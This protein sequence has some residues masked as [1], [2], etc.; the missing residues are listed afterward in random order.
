MGQHW[1]ATEDGDVYRFDKR[2]MQVVK[3]STYVNKKGY[4]VT[5][6]QG[7]QYYVHRLVAEMYLDTWNP[8]LQVNHKDGNKLNNRADNLEMVTNQQNRDHAI[9]L[10]LVNNKGSSNGNSK[11]SEEN[12]MFIRESALPT[13]K[14]ATQFGVNRKTISRVRYGRG[15]RHL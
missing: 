14:L 6:L 4:E 10:G 9:K 13:G 8:D 3:A 1:V 11:L 12:V 15:W 5:S 2:L 7:K